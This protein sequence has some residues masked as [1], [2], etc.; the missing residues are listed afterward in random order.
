VW[1]KS[2]SETVEMCKILKGSVQFYDRK[3][4]EEIKK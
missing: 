1:N 4:A 2:F 3:R